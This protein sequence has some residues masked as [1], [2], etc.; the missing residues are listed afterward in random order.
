[1]VIDMSKTP[2]VSVI[3]P[4]YNVEKYL[5]ECLNSI[6]NQTLKDIE[7][8]CVDDGSTDDS[9][10]ILNEYAQKDSRITVLTQ[11]N[12]GAAVARN[13]GLDIANGEYLSILDSDDFFDIT[14]LEKMY[15][16]AISTDADVVICGAKS[17]DEQ[18]KLISH[19]PYAL[20]RHL[21]PNKGVFNYKDIPDKIFQL[22][23][24]WSWNKLFKKCFIDKEKIKYQNLQY[25]NDFYF[26]YMV[27]IL[28]K[29]ITT[30]NENLIVYRI[31]TINQLT[32]TRDKNIFCFAKATFKLRREL[33]KRNI[34]HYVEQSF[35][36][37]CINFTLC[38][39]MVNIKKKMNKHKIR[40]FLKN[41]YFNIIN[42]ET[43][44]KNYF[45]NDLYEKLQMFY[46]PLYRIKSILKKFYVIFMI[47]YN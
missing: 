21:I 11:K 19:I 16:K 26:G 29:K 47:Q 5:K 25:L 37:W 24:A 8:I 13:K 1:M 22:T 44:P 2:K 18:S 4:V 30:I 33:I 6:V 20:N 9:L 3:I 12:Q 15:Y 45:Y 14:M 42:I 46:N 10:N 36:N 32:S 41:Y 17:I 28:A 7:I 31:N 34:Y 27:L 35:V 40:L 43:K 39:I 23:T 38:D